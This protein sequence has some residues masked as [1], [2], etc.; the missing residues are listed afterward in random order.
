MSAT[1]R[2][3]DY[4]AVIEDYTWRGGIPELIALLN[5]MLNPLGPSGSDPNPDL[6]AAQAAI[7][8]LG[9]R[10]IDYDETEF[11]EGRIY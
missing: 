3:G 9:G 4:T 1:I 6:H 8:I 7:E 10:I 2:V 5:A 11:V